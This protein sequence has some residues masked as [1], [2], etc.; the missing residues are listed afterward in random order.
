MYFDGNWAVLSRVLN[1]NDPSGLLAQATRLVLGPEQLETHAAPGSPAETSRWAV[2]RD[3]LLNR[4]CLRFELPT[5][6]TRAL[7]TRLR[8]SA[9]GLR[10]QISPYFAAGME[11]QLGRL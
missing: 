2:A 11:L 6:D 1:R 7:V 10:S 5:E 3:E 9:D 8:R 4:P